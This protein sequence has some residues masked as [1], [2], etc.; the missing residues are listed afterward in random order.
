MAWSGTVLAKST[1]WKPETTKKGGEAM[2]GKTNVKA[3]AV[4]LNR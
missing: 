3:G 2:K 4:M 1:G